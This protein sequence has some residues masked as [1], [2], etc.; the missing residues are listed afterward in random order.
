MNPDT[1][2]GGGAGKCEKQDAAGGKEGQ[3]E[4]NIQTSPALSFPQFSLTSQNPNNVLSGTSKGLSTAAA[5][6]VA[7]TALVVGG[8]VLGSMIGYNRYG[9]V[10]GGVGLLVGTVGGA[11]GGA[12]VAV[13]CIFTGFWQLAIGAIRTPS[14]IIGTASGK[15]WDDAA[16]EWMYSDLAEDAKRTLPMSD[17]DFLSALKVTGSAAAVYNGETPP[18]GA[19]NGRVATRKKL[20]DRELYDILGVEPEASVAEIKS[21]YY[22]KARQS[23]PDRNQNDPHAHVKFQ[24]VGEAYQILSDE[25]MRMAYDT[26]GKE[27]VDSAPKLDAGAMYAMIFGSE[28]FETLIGELQISTQIKGM[29]DGTNPPHDLLIFKQRKREIQ[30]AVNLASKLDVYNGREDEFLEKARAEAKDLSES[31]LG[32]SLLDLIGEVYKD[33]ARSELSYLDSLLISAK[34]NGNAFMEFWSTVIVGAQ[35]AFSALELSSLQAKADAKQK[36]EDDRNNV[37]QEER[38]ARKKRAAA[39]PFGGPPMGPGPSATEDEKKAYRDSTKN[40]TGHV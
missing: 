17:D 29:I 40:V 37:S 25:R 10:G 20:L 11:L 27:A 6:S 18:M 12:A 28:E 21:A 9:V 39:G 30:C 15:D 24:K 1:A 5:G 16:Q 38:E 4:S 19:T 34:Q 31:P 26:K 32:G 22:M 13:A 7:A 33:Q 14:A 36:A 3:S 2:T 35:A 23:H 8:P